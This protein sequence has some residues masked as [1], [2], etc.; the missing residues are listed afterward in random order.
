MLL[1]MRSGLLSLLLVIFVETYLQ[2]QQVMLPPAERRV[3]QPPGF[4]LFV[5]SINQ[6][7]RGHLWMGASN[8]LV[9]YDGQQLHLFHPEANTQDVSIGQVSPDSHGRV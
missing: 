4:D 5:T 7:K 1:A 8:G 3:T 6:D 2:A 9:R